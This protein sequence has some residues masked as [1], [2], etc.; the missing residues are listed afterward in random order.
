MKNPILNIVSFHTSKLAHSK[1]LPPEFCF[2][3][4]GYSKDGI[5]I[6]PSNKKVWTKAPTF[7]ELD[8]WL[9]SEYEYKIKVD[10]FVS[11]GNK[12]FG[13][14]IEKE[15]DTYPIY[16]EYSTEGF[17]IYEESWERAFNEVLKKI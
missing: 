11:E 3:G 10:S 4:G 14:I 8:Y 17:S 2:S 7:E 1:G 15:I 16:K 5:Y 12:L 13:Y 9:R 6:K